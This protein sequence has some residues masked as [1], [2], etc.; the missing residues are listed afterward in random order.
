ML[1]VKVEQSASVPANKTIRMGYLVT[2]MPIAGAINTA[3]ENAQNDGLLRDY[4]FRYYIF[5]IM[6]AKKVI[7]NIRLM[8]KS[9]DC[10]ELRPFVKS[11]RGCINFNEART[12][13]AGKL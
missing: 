6:V 11:L 2:Y 5:F 9:T 7:I 13:D 10:T 8:V 1:L 3:I 12:R 4:N